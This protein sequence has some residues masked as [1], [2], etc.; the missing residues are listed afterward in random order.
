MTSSPVPTAITYRANVAEAKLGISRSTIYR[1][2]KKG[3]LVL[4]KIGERAS[5]ITAD[6][7]HA[8]IERNKP[9]Q[10]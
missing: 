1:L 6:S 4:I 10:G 7:I 3:H 5:G 8:L 2:V 9:Q